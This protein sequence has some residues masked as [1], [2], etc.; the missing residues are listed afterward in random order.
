MGFDGAY[1]QQNKSF[2]ENMELQSIYGRADIRPNVW[3][4]ESALWFTLA[5][6]RI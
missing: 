6:L 3:L 1:K 5:R 4:I 2:L